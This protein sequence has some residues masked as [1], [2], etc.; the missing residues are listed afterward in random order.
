MRRSPHGEAGQVTAFVTVITMALVLATGLVVD[1]GR[2]IEA[3]RRVNNRAEQAARAGAQALSVEA[4]RSSGAQIIDEDRARAAVRD[5]LGRAGSEGK[6][7][8]VTG[9]SVTVEVTDSTSLLILGVAGLADQAV[10]GTGTA[11]NVRGVTTAES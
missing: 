1:G 2:L 9:D 7:L 8:S 3:K 10:R 5:Y 6:V 4:L 11:R